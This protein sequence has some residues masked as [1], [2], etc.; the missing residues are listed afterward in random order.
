MD[1]F[2]AENLR[3]LRLEAGYT[4]EGIAGIID[5]S[6][7]SVA[8]WENGES[9]PD[10]INCVKLAKLFRLSL[11][12]F[13]LMPVSKKTS[14]EYSDASVKM[15]GSTSINEN[16]QLKIPVEMMDMFDIKPGEEVMLFAD[17]GKGMAIAKLSRFE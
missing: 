4:L 3:S 2:I 12:A 15:M 10:I 1:I 6:R 9:L 11:D 17:K 14:V 13:V 16:C 7:Q 8:K 5:V